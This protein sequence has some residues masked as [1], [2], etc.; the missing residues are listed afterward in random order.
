MNS[1]NTEIFTHIKACA[2]YTILSTA[3]KNLYISFAG[4][5]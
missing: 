5:N 3:S 2:D 1:S 4:N